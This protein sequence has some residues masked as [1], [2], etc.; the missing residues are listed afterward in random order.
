MSVSRMA[1]EQIGAIGGA[2]CLYTMGSVFLVFT[3]GFP[4]RQT[5]TWRYLCLGSALFASYE[6]LFSLSF[7]LAE[8]RLQ[9]IEVTIVNYLWPALTVL[10][11]VLLSGKRTHWAVYPS[12]VIAFLGVVLSLSGD[13]TT[14]VFFLLAHTQQNPVVYLMALAGAFIWAVYCNLTKYQQG[15]GNL[16]TPFFMVTTC[17]LWVKFFLTRDAHITFT[18]TAGGYLVVAAGLMAAGYAL[19]NIA[20]VGG[21]MVFVA[22][23]SYFTPILSALISSVVLQVAL[24]HRFWLGVCM[25]T[26]GSLLSW[27]LTRDRSSA[28]SELS[29]S[30][31]EG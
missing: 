10:M 17:V 30:I 4:K 9:A 31:K 22:T 23:L 2:A 19:W 18:W 27:W 6:V 21:N 3:V 1:M 5:F 13:K 20:I 11:A 29:V 25:I 24:G 7:G 28:G 16:I 26:L 8:N 12:I 15:S 14:S